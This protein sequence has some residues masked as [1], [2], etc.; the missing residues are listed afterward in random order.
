VSEVDPDPDEPDEGQ[1]RATLGG[2]AQ[3]AGGDPT[4]GGR[5]GEIGRTPSIAADE[6]DL[7]PSLAPGGGRVAEEADAAPV[8]DPG[9]EA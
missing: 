1:G 7:G 3:P 5:R 2:G 8:P 9:P 6:P 4:A